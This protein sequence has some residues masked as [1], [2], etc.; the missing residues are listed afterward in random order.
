MIVPVYNA[1]PFLRRC[2]D[3]I[4]SQKFTDGELLL[5]DDGSQDRSGAICDQYAERDSRVRVFH[6]ANGGVSSARN[7]GLDHARGEWITFCDA[8]DWVSADTLCSDIGNYNEDLLIYSYFTVGQGPMKLHELP[9]C[10]LSDRRSLS[11]YC[12]KNLIS[13]VFRSPWSKF[14]K[15][16]R[17]YDIRFDERVRLGEDTLFMLDVLNRIQSCRVL[18][19]PL[20]VYNISNLAS[21][22]QLSIAES[23]YAMK[24]LFRAYDL[25]GV[26]NRQVEKYFFVDYKL[27]CQGEINKTPELWFKDPAV[28]SFY[29]RVKKSLGLNYRLRYRLLS[30]RTVSCLNRFLKR[31]D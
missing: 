31:K 24:A 28:I 8:D 26:E 29:N 6:K 19:A 20:Y 18:V 21:K 16:E 27:Y 13:S 14:F 7:V 25:L 15:R 3:S 17:I 12:S 2:V 23:I 11:D 30:N 1:E 22:Y 10:I 9:E 5:I 4:L